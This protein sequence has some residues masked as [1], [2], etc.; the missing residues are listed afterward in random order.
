VAR[1]TTTVVAPTVITSAPKKRAYVCTHVCTHAR[2]SPIRV[3]RDRV[4]V[5]RHDCDARRLE[6]ELFRPALLASWERASVSSCR[7]GSSLQRAA[8]L[9]RRTCVPPRAARPVPEALWAP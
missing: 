7:D 3:G 2:L 1:A 8:L 5:E 9:A 4:V 6:F